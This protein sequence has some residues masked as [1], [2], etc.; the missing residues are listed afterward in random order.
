[1]VGRPKWLDQ[2]VRSVKECEAAANAEL[3]AIENWSAADQ[4][5]RSARSST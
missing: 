4:P 5:V 3:D 1:M 2:D